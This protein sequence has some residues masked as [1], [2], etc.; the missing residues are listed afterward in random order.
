MG[1][2]L[3]KNITY[4]TNISSPHQGESGILRNP[5]VTNKALLETHHLGCKTV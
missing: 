2:N 4:G 3:L 1:A 5:Y